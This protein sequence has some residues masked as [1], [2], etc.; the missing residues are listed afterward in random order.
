[1]KLSKSGY[2]DINTIKN[3]NSKEFMELNEGDLIVITGGFP[4]TETKRITNL[5]KIEEI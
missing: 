4:N 3:L 1:M 5:M 2:G